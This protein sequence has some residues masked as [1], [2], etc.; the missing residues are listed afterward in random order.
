MTMNSS[1]F[2]KFQE[3]RKLYLKHLGSGIECRR[4]Y[5]LAEQ[6]YIRK[7]GNRKY[8]NLNSFKS[9]QSIVTKRTRKGGK[10][11]NGFER[12]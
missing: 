5:Q 11:K 7:Y 6:D 1:R 2:D 10:V 8:K 4:A 9:S 12:S 3:F